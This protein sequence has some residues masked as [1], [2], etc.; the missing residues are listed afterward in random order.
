MASDTPHVPADRRHSRSLAPPHVGDRLA[1]AL[2]VVSILG[3][4]MFIMAIA[5]IAGGLSFGGRFTEPPPN[6]DEMG[7]G[8]V[9][10]GALLLLLSLAELVVVVA[11]VADWRWRQL[12]PLRP[13]SIAAGLNALLALLA[14][15]GSLRAL[16]AGPDGEIVIA[17]AL[18]AAA[19][20]FTVTTVILVVQLRGSR[21]GRE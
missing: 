7:R 1:A 15:F 17:L 12:R 19:A 21:V 6:V 18:A 10:A 11:I 4:G 13:R 20:A 14:A 8:Q 9:V 16:R 5:I 3:L 2:L